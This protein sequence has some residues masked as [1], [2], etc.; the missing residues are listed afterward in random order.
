MGKM[1]LGAVNSKLCSQRTNET[2]NGLEENIIQ[3]KTHAKFLNKQNNT[4]EYIRHYL[5][6]K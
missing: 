4:T 6:K 2:N 5:K 1:E 3:L